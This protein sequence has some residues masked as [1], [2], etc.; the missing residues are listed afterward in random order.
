M[1]KAKDVEFNL[2]IP[3]GTQIVL[4]NETVVLNENQFHHKGTVGKIARL[5]TDAFHAFQI[6]FPDGTRGMANRTDFSGSQRISD[7]T[8]QVD[9]AARRLSVVRFRHLSLRRQLRGLSSV[10]ENQ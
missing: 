7:R 10:F 6:E 1:K 9:F 8:K 2:I 3:K 4:L 5:P